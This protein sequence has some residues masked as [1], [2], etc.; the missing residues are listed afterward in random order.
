MNFLFGSKR[1][2]YS[3]SIITRK[4]RVS[5]KMWVFEEF[6]VLKIMFWRMVSDQ[7]LS[8]N[9]VLNGNVGTGFF[10]TASDA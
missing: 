7:W 1:L 2:S 6:W 4:D 3:K 5:Y 9:F 10:K 8:R